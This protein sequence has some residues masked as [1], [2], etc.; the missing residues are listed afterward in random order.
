MKRAK[1]LMGVLAFAV[2]AMV[3][4][5]RAEAAVVATGTCG[6]SVNWVLDDA[7]TLTISGQGPMAD[8][9][10]GY[11]SVFY[12]NRYKIETVV[13]ND[14]ITKIGDH[15]FDFYNN[16]E[17]VTLPN[18]VTE[19]GAY[20]FNDSDL[21]TIVM[22]ENIDR[23]GEY[24]FAWTDLEKIYVPRGISYVGSGAFYC[25]DTTIYFDGSLNEWNA[26]LEEEYDEY[27]DDYYIVFSVYDINYNLKGGKNNNANPRTYVPEDAEIILQAPT[28]KGYTFGGW[29]DENNK[30]IVKI[31]RGSKHN[32]MLTAKW[33]KDTY[34]ITYKLNGGTNNSKNKATYTVL[35]STITLKNPTKKG[36][37]F[38][39]WFTDKAMTRKATPIEKGSTGNRTFYAKWIKNKYTI[40]Y[41]L[42]GGKNKSD[43]PK[44]Y[45][46]SSKTIKL[47]TPTK[48]GYKFEGWYSNEKM[49]K[50]VTE[51]AK[52]S[53]GNVTLY[54]KWKLIEYTITY[55]LNG[56]K[57]N[58]DNPAKY[59]QLTATIKLKN[60]TKTGYKF[61]GWF[62][63][64]A[65]TQKVTKIAKGSTGNRTLYAKWTKITYTI[66]YNLNGGK[67]N[68]GNPKKYDVTKEPIKLLKPTKDGYVFRGWYKESTFKTK[69]TTIKKGA[70]GN[71]KLYAKWAENKANW[72]ASKN[73]YD[74]DD[75]T[76]TLEWDKLY[77]QGNDLVLEA[78]LSN[79][80]L[81][82]MDKFDEITFWIYDANDKILINEKT[83]K[84]ISLGVGSWKTKVVKFTFKNVPIRDITGASGYTRYLYTYHYE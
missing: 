23:I 64:K 65:M 50:K 75:Y 7:G 46:V 56:G 29:Y 58:S 24:A 68:S 76:D 10:D 44:T 2:M 84:N 30:K 33:S 79:N 83:L 26:K 52:G 73:W 21:K 51:I 13:V 77:Y 18:T 61:G 82:K 60:P 43:N 8:V 19:I 20:A 62:S 37:T 39:G 35:S 11:D 57:N 14:G 48:K 74:Y 4:V 28:K 6:K 66:T 16:I 67:N 81:Y 54:A 40:T 41:N 71:L 5:I 31:P 27:Y 55:K 59:S 38:A 63:D 69:V 3:F 12:D 70:T 80:H 25:T 47:K 42:N 53:T 72:H 36:Y 32:Y 17:R 34:T 15:A 1:A 49:T 9:T 45:T 22:S 78:V